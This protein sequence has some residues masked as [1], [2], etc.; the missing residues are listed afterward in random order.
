MI[1]RAYQREEWNAYAIS[2]QSVM[3]SV[4]F[5]LNQTVALLMRGHVL[6]CGC[7]TAKIAPFV[8]EQPSVTRYTGIDYSGLMV[9]RARWLLGQFQCKPSEIIHAKIENSEF[10]DPIDCCLSINSYYAWDNPQ[11]VLAWIYE[12]LRPGGLFVLATPNQSLNMKQLLKTLDKELI[13]HP[14]YPEFRRMNLEFCENPDVSF[15]DM[16]DLIKQVQ[17]VGFRVKEAHQHCYLGGLNF[18]QLIK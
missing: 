18:L 9:D 7:G 14:N 16:N 10:C 8:L 11:T 12:I 5:E 3:P 4:M 13:A 17:T 6:D 15:V 2:H 1:K